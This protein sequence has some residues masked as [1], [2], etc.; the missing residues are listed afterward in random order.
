[1]IVHDTPSREMRLL[2]QTMLDSG[3]FFHHTCV[4][5]HDIFWSFAIN[6]GLTATMKRKRSWGDVRT[7]PKWTSMTGRTGTEPARSE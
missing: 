4:P 5:R 7:S 2:P 3:G 6:L 1:M